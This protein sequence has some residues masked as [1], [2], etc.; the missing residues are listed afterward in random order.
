MSIYE[1]AEMKFRVYR[2]S[3]QPR[4]GTERTGRNIWGNGYSIPDP[5]LLSKDPDLEPAAK[6]D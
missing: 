4:R 6:L 3:V 1:I 2:H 5:D